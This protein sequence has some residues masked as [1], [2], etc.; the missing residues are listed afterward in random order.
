VFRPSVLG[1]NRYHAFDQGGEDDN[2]VKDPALPAESVTL[3]MWFPGLI[4]VVVLAC[5]V[6][7]VQYGMP[8]G[9]SIL[10]MGLAF[11]FSFLA[12]QATGATGKKYTHGINHA[13]DETQTL[14]P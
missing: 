12:I 4:S 5:I 13:T 11:F 7:R 8:I 10:A 6:M 1:Q 14:H 9:E 3:W 2:L